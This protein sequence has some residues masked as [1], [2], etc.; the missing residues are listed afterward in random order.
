MI[1]I[2]VGAA[3]TFMFDLTELGLAGGERSQTRP[4]TFARACLA[5]D[6]R[7]I[8][9][10]MAVVQSNGMKRLSIVSHF[11]ESK[12]FDSS[13]VPVRDE[14]RAYDVSGTRKECSQI[15]CRG[16]NAQVS[17]V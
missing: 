16:L 6:H 3:T 14:M 10:E 4:M 7:L 15:F 8:V 2:S 9:E 1:A 5:H 17:D 12:A 11:D 13:G